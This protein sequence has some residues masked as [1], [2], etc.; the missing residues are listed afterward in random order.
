LQ[1]TMGIVVYDPQALKSNFLL[2]ISQEG[3]KLEI[4][5]TMPLHT[6]WLEKGEMVID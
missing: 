4:Y 1:C 5:N 6:V 2:F 3:P